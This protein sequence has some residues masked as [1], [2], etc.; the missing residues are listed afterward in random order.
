MGAHM[1]IPRILTSAVSV[2]L[3][4]LLVFTATA[5]AAHH[6][7]QE[8]GSDPTPAA[9][10]SIEREF[11]AGGRTSSYRIFSQD[12]DFSKPVGVVVRLHGDGD[13]ETTR[14]E[15][16]LS[17]LAAVAADHNMILVAPRAPE[18]PHG[19]I[20]WRGLSDHV[21]WLTQLLQTEIFVIDGVDTNN[22]WWMGYSGGAELITY[23]LLP[24]AHDLVTG[25]A[26]MAGGGGAPNNPEMSAVDSDIRERLPLTWVVGTRDDGTET[27]DGF[28]A[29]R[30]AHRG[31]EFYHTRGF[32]AVNLD[33][34][35]GVGHYDLPQ[36]EILA[37]FLNEHA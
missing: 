12:V 30:A 36:P 26:I 32:E 34:L 29:V 3:A 22:L 18:G 14:P 17:E 24:L 11:T 2:V 31:S 21:Q 7:D 28:D 20:W 23:G 6:H 37:H 10:E 1:A 27:P 16:L 19:P 5:L 9:R 33:L 8:H 13:G 25:G 4:L 35:P 15:G